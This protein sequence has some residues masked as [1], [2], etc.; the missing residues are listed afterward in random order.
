MTYAPNNETHEARI[1]LFAKAPD[2]GRAKTRLV[3]VLGEQGAAELQKRLIRNALDRVVRE[4]MPPTELWCAPDSEHP[5]FQGLSREYSVTLRDQSGGDLGARMLA[6]ARDGLAETGHVILLGTDS[7][8][9]SPHLIRRASDALAGG[10]D[11]VIGPAHDG[12]YVLLGLSRLQEGIFRNIPW[13]TERVLEETRRRL[14]QLG[15]SWEELPSCGDLDR[16]QDLERLY[17]SGCSEIQDLVR[18]LYP[19]RA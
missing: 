14:A 3:P 1:L 10:R 11:A 13:G 8:E 4:A 7:P 12:G 2:P 15:F 16:R 19:K 6:A 18:G 9:L 5:F 17:Q